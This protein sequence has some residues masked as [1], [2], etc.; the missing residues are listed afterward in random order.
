LANETDRLAN[1]IDQ[2]G[3]T[4]LAD[5]PRLLTHRGYRAR[6]TAG[7]RRSDPD[8]LGAFWAGY[9]ALSP[10]QMASVGEPVLSK[11]RAIT[12]RR[13]AIDHGV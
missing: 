9:D 3:V 6:I 5:I 4:T 2:A 12:S 11:L 13:F 8:G 1:G 10:A 7:V